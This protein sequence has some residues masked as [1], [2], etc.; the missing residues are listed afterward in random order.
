M[1]SPLVSV[2]ITAFNVEEYLPKA[3]DSVLAQQTS[4]PIEIIVGDDC[5]KDSTVSIARSYQERHPNLVRVLERSTNLGMSRNYYD[6]FEQCR[7]KYIAWLDADDHWTDPDKLE[8]QVKA[9]ESDPSIKVCCHF[10]RWVAPDGE[11]TRDKYPSTAPGRY[12]L[13]DILRRN[14]V[15]SLS[16]VFRNG[17]HRDLPSWYFDLAPLSDWPLWVLAACSGDILLL[18]RVMA[19]YRLT[20]D[21]AFTGKGPLHGHVQDVRFYDHIESSIP[22]HMHRIVRREKGKR[23]ESIAYKLRKQGEFTASRKAAFKAFHSPAIMDNAGSKT[24]ALVA[25]SVREIQWRLRNGSKGADRTVQPP[26]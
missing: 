2:A 21:S 20:P 3:L 7:G 16:A 23:Y 8:I 25:A 10:V 26:S 9:L 17:A 13:K 11:I 18:D 19:D 22:S 14:I 12:G 4:F 15:P 1:N 6:V 5:S 24:K